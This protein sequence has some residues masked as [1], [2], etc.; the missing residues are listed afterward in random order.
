VFE[1]EDRRRVHARHAAPGLDALMITYRDPNPANS[2][3]RIRTGRKPWTHTDPRRARR[4]ATRS[5]CAPTR[6][7][8]ARA[9]ASPSAQG[10]GVR[11]SL[12][13]AGVRTAAPRQ[14]ARRQQINFI[15]FATQTV[16]GAPIPLSVAA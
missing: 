9:V 4:L 8:I 15:G 7:L 14:F 1:S 12:E 10:G 2:L 11:P 3:R 16:S 13:L 6:R 5:M